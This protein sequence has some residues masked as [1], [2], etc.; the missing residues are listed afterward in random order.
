MKLV[1]N[2][3]GVLRRAWSIRLILLAGILSGAEVAMSLIGDALP[4]PAGALAA[5]S[6]FVACA[7]FVA[8][9]SAQ[10]DLTGED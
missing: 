9:L 8:R 5:L 7:A 10:K 4:L 1:A 2:W 6:A 3:R